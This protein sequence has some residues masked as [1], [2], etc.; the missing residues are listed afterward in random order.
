MRPKSR[1]GREEAALLVDTLEDMRHKEALSFKSKTKESM[2]VQCYNL[3][4]RTLRPTF[5]PCVPNLG[6]QAAFA[7]QTNGAGS[8]EVASESVAVFACAPLKGY[9]K[10]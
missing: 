3:K 10:L 1:R 5:V 4:S 6:L 9:V 7:G 2:N 8:I